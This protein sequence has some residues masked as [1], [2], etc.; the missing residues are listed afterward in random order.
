LGRMRTTTI[1]KSSGGSGEIFKYR[2]RNEDPVLRD[3]GIDMLFRQFRPRFL[4][5]APC[6][7][8]RR[9]TM[10]AGV[11]FLG[12]AGGRAF[13]GTM[14]ALAYL[15]FFR[16]VRPYT[17]EATNFVAYACAWLVFVMFLCGFLVETRIFGYENRVLGTA[18]LAFTLIFLA[19]ALYFGVAEKNHLKETYLRQLEL[20]LR[21]AEVR[22]GAARML[23]RNKN[24]ITFILGEPGVGGAS[25][26]GCEAGEVGPL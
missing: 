1:F 10:I 12:E 11:S 21:D 24:S 20:Q 3:L 17:D 7:L 8:I 9:V 25:Q 16:E 2:S 26:K 4:Y 15:L 23:L 14:L 5:A 22:T 19:L 18:M 13:H 6:E